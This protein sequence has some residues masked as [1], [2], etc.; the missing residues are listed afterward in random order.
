MN[1]AT[2]PTE[3]LTVR[4]HGTFTAMEI[5]PRCRKP[6]PVT[7]ETT[8]VSSVPIVRPEQAPAAFRLRDHCGR[9]RVERRSGPAAATCT[10]ATPTTTAP[11]ASW[12]PIWPPSATARGVRWIPR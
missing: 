9:G 10:P 7:H 3:Y 6:R 8:A 4:A 11:R 2:A 1:T 12:T 5:P